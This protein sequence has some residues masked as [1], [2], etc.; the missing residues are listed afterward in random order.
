MKIRSPDEQQVSRIVRESMG[1]GVLTADRFPTGACHFVYDVVTESG[2]NV[3]VRVARPENRGLL[4]SA[5]YWGELLRP[6]G[7]PLPNVLY[8]DTDAANQPFPYMIIERLAGSD[9][10]S[11][12]PQLSRDEKRIL[13]GEVAH[14][15]RIAGTLPPGRGFGYARS[16]EGGPFLG[17]WADVLYGSLGTSRSRIEAV[18]AADARHVDRVE[19]M[20]PKYEGY[21]SR[22]VPRCFLDDTTTKNVIVH[23]GRLSGVVDVDSVCFGDSLFPI[24]LTRMSLLNTGFD[25]DYT[26][27]WCEAAGVTEEQRG[28]LALYT[29][30]FCVDFMGELGHAFNREGPPPVAARDV[31]RLSGILDALLSQT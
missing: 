15:Q 30:L 1:E 6:K 17:S 26:E 24:A 27:F 8:A 12:Y 31:E 4:A 10:G 11:V 9:L 2:R 7:V 13:A 28:V 20:I 3:V 29:A 18:G 19:S 22:V 23:G 14:A 16:Y 25:P 5:I 21:L